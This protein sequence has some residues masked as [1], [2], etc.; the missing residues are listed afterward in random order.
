MKSP[1]A[2]TRRLWISR[3]LTAGALVGFILVVYVGV[4][5]G[6]GRLVGM[7]EEPSLYLQIVATALV[8]ILFQPVRVRLQ[9]WANRIVYGQRA[10]PYQVLAA[11]SR[12]A[13][14][15]SDEAS[16]QEVARLLAEGTGAD[17]AMVWLRVGDGLWPVASFPAS[18]SPDPVELAGGSL[19]DLGRDLV[20][21]VVHESE[22]LGALTLDKR[23]GEEVTPQDRELVGRLAVGV[24]VMLRNLRLT[25]E[26]RQRL[27]ELTASRR[28]IVTAQDEARRRLERD[29]DEGAQQK[30]VSLKV[31]LG[32][33]RAMAEKA[34]AANTTGLLEELERDAGGAV[35]TLRDLARGI[36]PPLLEEEGLGVAIKAQTRK[37]ALP[38]TVHSAGVG[39]YPADVE[40]A[41]YFVVLESLNNVAK[42]SDASSAYV[43]LEEDTDELTFIVE[44][45][46]VG[47]DPAETASGTG[48]VGMADRLDTVGGRL[49]VASRRGHGTVVKGKVPVGG[50]S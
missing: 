41:V 46:G 15:T 16:L 34:R 17:P 12:Q 50:A 9:R 35:E 43:R 11:F 2:S 10:T 31:K 30:L 39:R 8:A 14:Q 49:E 26:L 29:L 42:Y 3:T 28:R 23:R 44:D 21:P 19:P 13:G 22:V 40:T 38:V 47:F 6:L 32:L 48:M 37:A 24:A 1:S 36:Y 20:V 5:V 18:E 27:Q 25:S 45:D 33:L 4:V 7:G